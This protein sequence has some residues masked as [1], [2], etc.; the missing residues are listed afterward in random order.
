MLRA[1][2]ASGKPLYVNTDPRPSAAGNRDI[3]GTTGVFISTIPDF[4]YPMPAPIRNPGENKR[5]IVFR[6]PFGAYLRHQGFV[7]KAHSFEWTSDLYKQ[8]ATFE[9]ITPGV[10]TGATG[11]ASFRSANFPDRFLAMEM[12]GDKFTGRLII[13]PRGQGMSD[14][15]IEPAN[16]PMEG[17]DSEIYNATSQG[18]TYAQTPQQAEQTCADLGGRIATVDEL[19]R[20][21]REGATWCASGWTKTASGGYKG[22]W[23]MQN[24]SRDI[25]MACGRPYTVTEWVSSSGQANATCIAPKPP[26]SLY[27]APNSYFQN[28]IMGNVGR[29]Q[30]SGYYSQNDKSNM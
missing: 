2:S 23:P 20:A 8:D 28:S 21:Q 11:T 16:I 13:A 27:N 1:Q 14:F 22:L 7:M 3:G 30:F 6:T 24:I 18:R 12:A 25:G 5:L 17:R 29:D 15:I 26:V 9:V 19:E 10:R 4:L